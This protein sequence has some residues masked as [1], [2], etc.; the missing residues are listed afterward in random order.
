MID[1]RP[2]KRPKVSEVS[3]W[4]TVFYKDM[5]YDRRGL[6]GGS[7]IVQNGEP[8]P[9]YYKVI[10]YPAHGKRISKLFYGESAYFDVVRYVNDLG[11]PEIH[12]A[13]I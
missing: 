6:G 10:F 5:E 9:D 3:Y 2:S 12:S 4:H 1:L 7:V 13:H 8:Y 11:F